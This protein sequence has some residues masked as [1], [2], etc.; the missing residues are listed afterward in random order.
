MLVGDYMTI[1]GSIDQP[2]L[3][4]VG[5]A[6]MAAGTEAGVTTGRPI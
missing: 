6:I 2:M 4:M 3:T 1:G 5:R